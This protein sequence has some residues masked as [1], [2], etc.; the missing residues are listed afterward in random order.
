MSKPVSLGPHPQLLPFLEEFGVTYEAF[1]KTGRPTDH[2]VSVRS[3]VITRLHEVGTSWADMIDITGL[4]NGT[5]QRL[6]KGK[7]CPAV[8]QKRAAI[9]AAVGRQ[10]KGLPKPQLSEQ[11][12][13]RW[14]EGLFDFHIGRKRSEAEKIRLKLAFTP[15]RKAK[16]SV[17][18]KKLWQNPAYRQ[19]LESYH[20]SDEERIRRSVAQTNRMRQ[21][22]E[23]WGRGGYVTG[24]KHTGHP[25]F[26]IRSRMEAMAVYILEEDP[27]VVSYDYEPLFDLPDGR[28]IMPDFQV[29]FADGS[30]KVI[31]VKPAWV[32][33]LEPTHRKTIRIALYRQVIA[34]HGLD[35]E[36]WTEED[37]L[38][39]YLKRVPW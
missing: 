34:D 6:T 33:R 3:A 15:D 29:W 37:K 23:R 21:N 12:R 17:A 26:W 16:M 20:R 1:R 8:Q 30:V 36:F 27:N 25:E 35:L 39:G 2:I 22:P 19:H 14:R 24:A 18:R 13:Q 7:R 38:H 9:G 32:F 31:E 10:L 11:M 28:Y 5:I 4:S